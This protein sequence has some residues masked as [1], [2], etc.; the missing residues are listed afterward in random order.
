ML[1]FCSCQQPYMVNLDLEDKLPCRLII[2]NVL[3]SEQKE[4]CAFRAIGLTRCCMSNVCVWTC[5]YW[6]HTIIHMC[7]HVTLQGAITSNF[8]LILAKG[9]SGVKC[10]WNSKFLQTSWLF[11]SHIGCRVEVGGGQREGH[12]A[13]VLEQHARIHFSNSKY[14]LKV[15]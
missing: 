5:Q 15:F 10:C 13:T 4:K 14:V 2:E 1:P 7:S 12:R 9:Y 8:S 11:W 6:C 3:E